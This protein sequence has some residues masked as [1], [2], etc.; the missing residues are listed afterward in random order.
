VEGRRGVQ[1]TYE[2]GS[3]VKLRQRQ[4]S[5]SEMSHG[6]IPQEVIEQVKAHLDS[7]P[8]HIRSMVVLLI[9]CGTLR[10]AAVIREQQQAMRDEQGSTTHLL[11]PN[12]KGFPFSQ[13]SPMLVLNRTTRERDIRDASGSA[14]RRERCL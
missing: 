5:R 3:A 2:G 4:T 12:H 10:A 14:E 13:R 11:F 7:L 6:G 9:Q 8:T 1:D